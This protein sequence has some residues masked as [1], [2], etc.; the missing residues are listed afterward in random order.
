M[1]TPRFLYREWIK[2]NI[3]FESQ[4]YNTIINTA[5]GNR[6]QMSGNN[7]FGKGATGLVEFS[8]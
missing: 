7:R 1:Q 4:S 8:S 5:G 3:P 2:R 6:V